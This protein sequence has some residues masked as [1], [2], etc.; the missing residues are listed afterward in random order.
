MS[1]GASTLAVV[2][3]VGRPFR[4]DYL[5]AFLDSYRTHDAGVEHELV[6]VFNGVPPGRG[7]EALRAELAGVRH[8]LLQLDPPVLD[9]AVYR[10]TAER[11]DAALVC[12]VNSHARILAPGWLEHLR[13][14]QAAPGVGLAG[15][16]GSWA[17]MRSL[18]AFDLGLPSA[19]R[20]TL[21]GRVEVRRVL[22]D[23]ER[24]RGTAPAAGPPAG[25]LDGLRTAANRGVG[26]LPHLLG[27][28]GYPDPH[29]RTN[30][31]LA[32]RETLVAHLPAA[33]T[34]KRDA[35]R[36]ESGRQSVTSQVE[37]SGL[38]AVV[39][40]R[41]GRSWEVADWPQSRTFWQQRQEHLLVADNQ[42]QSYELGDAARRSVLAAYAWGRAG[43]AG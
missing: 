3:L 39:V 2:H 41:H 6:V 22:L 25:R 37:R 9:L 7:R 40:D 30:A 19:Y 17:S 8:H 35:H 26:A 32:E 1:S 12:V 24:E 33:L 15:A 36:A 10:W 38:R 27:F 13:R 11:L 5:R 29:L 31:L 28:P 14:A 16:S 23:L 4:A 20:R 43:E 34:G 21:P 18:A 42:T